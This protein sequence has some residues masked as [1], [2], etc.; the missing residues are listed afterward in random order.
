LVVKADVAASHRGIKGAAS[1]GEAANGF[2]Q[3][4][5]DFG[6]EWVA[7]VEIV[8]GAEWTGARASEISGGFGYGD[9]AAFVRIEMDVGGVAIDR[10]GDEFVWTVMRYV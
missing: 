9:F 4:P 10:E 6:I 7:K 1:L 3:L 2:A 5:E 8:R